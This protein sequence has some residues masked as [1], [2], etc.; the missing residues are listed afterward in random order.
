VMGVRSAVASYLRHCSLWLWVALPLAAQSASSPTLTPHPPNIDIPLI[1]PAPNACDSIYDSFYESEPGVY[2]FW[3]LCEA[4]PQEIGYDYL[5]EW[6]LVHGIA[7]T[8]SITGGARGPVPDGETAARAPDATLKLEQQGIFL[9]KHAGTLAAWINADATGYPVTAESLHAVNGKS[10]VA[11]TVVNTGNECFSGDFTGSNGKPM[12]AEHCGVAPNTWHRVVVTWDNNTLSLFLDGLPQASSRLSGALD[13]AV[14]F[15][16]LFPGCCKTGKQMTLA[17]V[18]LANKAWTPQQVARDFRPSLITPP[19]GGVEITSEPLGLIHKD[20]LGYVEGNQDLSKPALVSAL[21]KGLRTAGATAVRYT[22]GAFA[23][24]EDWRGD[25]TLCTTTKGKTELS[26]NQAT[27]NTLDNYMT[28]VVRPLGLDPSFVVNYGSN[29]PA[30][31]GGDDPANAANLVRYANVEHHY[32]I[33]RWEIG[34]EQYAYGGGPLIDLHPNPYLATNGDADS[35]YTRYEPAFYVA[36][37]A[38]DPSIK[39]AVP[40]AN[41]H[42]GYDALAHYQI[43]LLE[44]A[45]FDALVLHSYPI[46]NPITDG[47]TL[48]PD[49]VASG[50]EVRGTL[51]SFQTQLLDAGKSPDAIW[52]TE[53]SAV[54]GGNLWSKQTIGAVIPLFAAM[55]LAEFMQAGVPFA[56]WQAQGETDVCSGYN[57]SDDAKSSYV[58]WNGCGDTALVYAGPIDGVDEKHVGFRQGDIT[59]AARAFQVL[60][61]SGFVTE[62]EHMVRIQTD[63]KGAPWL[64]AYA[65]THGSSYAVLLINRDREEAH[66]LPV[67]FAAR[68]S[69]GPVTQWTYGREQYDHTRTGDWSIAPAR[70]TYPSWTGLFNAQLAPWSVSVFVFSK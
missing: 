48:Y 21:N 43:P 56:S 57:Y 22:G 5:G 50:T 41:L 55:Q 1:V 32:G 36:M 18:A 31:N 2:A 19:R 4:K 29:P 15:Y 54:A 35:T 62:G 49:R 40:S 45:R 34:N 47:A 44:H 68:S 30:C 63:S 23:D 9:N 6:P 70:V 69:G 58:W 46:T 25:K 13:D 20:V 26:R 65:A 7:P 42:G 52:V 12:R 28:R 17:K 27:Q 3:V 14:F 11:I 60:S 66:Q 61:E 24:A 10:S 16:Q 8:A 67:H 39:I 53:W 37:K 38:Q 64:M 59:P 33:S 51:L